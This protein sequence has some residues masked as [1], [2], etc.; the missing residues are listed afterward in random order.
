MKTETAVTRAR[1]LA[2]AFTT[3]NPRKVWALRDDA[4][5]WMEEAIHDAHNAIGLTMPDDWAYATLANIADELASRAMDTV[6]IR[7]DLHEIADS[8]VDIYTSELTA[9]LHTCPVAAACIDDAADEYGPIHSVV[10]GIARGQYAA[11][12]AMATSLLDSIEGE[13]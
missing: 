9:W 11:I 13:G 8:L 6:D 2:E 4:P 5:Q 7:D 3:D 10:S 12:Y 1:D